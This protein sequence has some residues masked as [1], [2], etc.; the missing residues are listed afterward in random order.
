MCVHIKGT[1]GT[2]FSVLLITMFS[3]PGKGWLVISSDSQVF[4]P[5]NTAFHLPI[6]QSLK[7][8]YLT[9]YPNRLPKDD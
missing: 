1:H 5:I 6:K 7:G 9:S 3:L 2:Y 4:L 8:L